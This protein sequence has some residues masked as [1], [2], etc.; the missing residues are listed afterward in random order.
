M[1]GV[2]GFFD[3]M[4][5]QMAVSLIKDFELHVCCGSYTATS[6]AGHDGVVDLRE[7]PPRASGRRRPHSQSRLSLC[8]ITTERTAS[9][10]RRYRQYRYT[11]SHYT[12]GKFLSYRT[13]NKLLCSAGT[14]C[15]YQ[16]QRIKRR[17]Y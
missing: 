2:S 4:P 17:S 12:I 5:W 8:A 11:I 14:T 6:W 15:I 3:M 13:I 7:M 10:R 9:I 1:S 16:R